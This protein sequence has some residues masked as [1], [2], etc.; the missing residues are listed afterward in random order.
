MKEDL[1]IALVY[2][3]YTHHYHPPLF[4]EYINK[5]VFLIR[6]NQ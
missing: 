2:D 5:K 1:N 6:G 3:S 4:D